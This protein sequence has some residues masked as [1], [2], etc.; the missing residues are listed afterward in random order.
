VTASQ[1]DSLHAGG[2][3]LLDRLDEAAQ[4]YTAIPNLT[5][6]LL[7][8]GALLSLVCATLGYV[9]LGEGDQHQLFREIGPVSLFSLL[10]TLA[11]A[12]LGVLIARREKGTILDWH[13]L[14]NFWLLAGIGFVF[15]A[16]DELIDIHGQAGRWLEDLVTGKEPLGFHGGGDM[17][18]AVYLLVGLVVS[19]IYI[20][21]LAAD[22][23]VLVKFFAGAFLIGLTVLIDGFVEQTSWVWVLEETLKLFA[24]SFLVGA[25]ARRFQVAV[26][27][28][29][30]AESLQATTSSV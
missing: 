20:R 27:S 18:L 12:A 11:I 28:A 9:V 17:I 10:Q 15:L 21:E 5:V 26:K 29:Q 7:V 1:S 3:R 24:G 6:R 22:R 4:R 2:S 13:D 8:A 14:L 23:E 19:L 25:F 30:P 16:I